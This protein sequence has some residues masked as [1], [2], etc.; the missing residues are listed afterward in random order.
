MIYWLTI[1]D[2]L[3]T[4]SV[5]DPQDR[6]LLAIVHGMTLSSIG[7]PDLLQYCVTLREGVARLIVESGKYT[8]VHGYR[9]N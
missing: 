9:A 5:D 8:V 3:Q 7:D 4:C 1:N 2:A 6:N